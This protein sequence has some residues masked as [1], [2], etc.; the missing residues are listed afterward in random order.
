MT[1]PD[2]LITHNTNHRRESNVPVLFYE[3]SQRA[4]NE[5][6]SFS[7]TS[8]IIAIC[9]CAVSISRTDEAY[10]RTKISRQDEPLSSAR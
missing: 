2:C 4:K 1:Y 7:T 6:I 10:L 8:M 5:T 9:L 3:F